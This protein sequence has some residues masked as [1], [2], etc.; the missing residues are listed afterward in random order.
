MADYQKMYAVL[1]GAIDDV[2]DGLRTIPLAQPY[3]R[4]LYSAL[5]AAVLHR[6]YAIAEGH[7]AEI[8]SISIGIRKPG[9]RASSRLLCSL[10]ATR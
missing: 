9:R 10:T 3:A 8:G 4:Q 2:L 6:G 7:T 5:L 1:C